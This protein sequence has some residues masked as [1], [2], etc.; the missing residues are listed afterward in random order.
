MAKR[1]RLLSR[2]ETLEAVPGDVLVDVF[3]TTLRTKQDCV[4]GDGLVCGPFMLKAELV[5][6]LEALQNGK[7]IRLGELEERIA[8][9]EQWVISHP[10]SNQADTEEDDE[11]EVSFVGTIHIDRGKGESFCGIAK[12]DKVFS[13]KQVDA[14]LN[15]E[16]GEYANVCLACSKL[17]W[18]A[19][20]VK[21]QQKGG[22]V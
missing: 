4:I 18:K 16:K 10:V 20:M 1:I 19:D 9:L 8:N 22:S 12:G 14:I 21:K 15:N 17:Y 3:E 11:Q 7:Q 5:R 13:R 2:F 6:R